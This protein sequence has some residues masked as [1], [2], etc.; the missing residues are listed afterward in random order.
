[1]VP[2]AGLAPCGERERTP[3]KR[4]GPPVRRVADLV[5]W[6]GAG[7]DPRVTVRTQADDGAANPTDG[8]PPLRELL[9]LRQVLR[10]LELPLDVPGADA[11][12][13]VRR[14]TI[15]QLDDYV[16][17][18]F[19]TLDAPVLAV[20]GGSTGA[21]KSTL[22][23]ALV[24]A[25]V[26]RS[27]AIR[28]TTRD[29]V[30][31]HHP[32]DGAW[33]TDARILP[34]LARLQGGTPPAATPEPVTT[35]TAAPGP[36][37]LVLAPTPALVPG[38]ALLD[39][40]DVDSVVDANRALATQLLAAADLW[41]FVTSANRY[42]D[43]VPWAL[44]REAASRD[45]EVAVVLDRVPARVVDEVRA[46]LRAMLDAEGLAGAPLFTVLETDLGAG[47]L[48]PV[49]AVSE[50]RDWLGALAGDATARAAVVRRTLT[51]AVAALA[52]RS[53]ALARAA[54]AQVLGAARLHG[55]VDEAYAAAT[56]AVLH[57]TDD[58]SLLRGEVLARWQ[59]FVGTGEL[60]RGLQ[61]RVGVVRDRIGAFLRGRPQ[62][63]AE[64]SVAIEHGLAS[65][66][67]MQAGAAADHAQ[68]GLDAD[69]A[70]RALLAG[71]DLAHASVGFE[72]V[73]AEEIRRWQ[74]AL[75]DLVRSQGQEKRTT[76]RL[77]AFGVNG[78][79]V[80]LMIVAF[81]STGGL[82]GAEIGIAGGTA[83]VAQKVLEAVF[84][85]QAVRS[86]ARTALEDLRRRCEALMAGERDAFL[87]RLGPVAVDEGAGDSLRDA[88]GAARA[89]VAATSEGGER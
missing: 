36:S 66:V 74:G 29:P 86:L 3:P 32:A 20:V 65:L 67:L 84:G 87:A 68:A 22:V 83:I 10:A 62:P 80:A 14:E 52:Q 85:D 38:L 26:S 37:C 69:P 71:R 4:R 40:P 48:L 49:E 11:A 1:M 76:A 89:A 81:A 2:E 47:G 61:G 75:L 60:F 34:G 56:E 78:V 39:A 79:G 77:L 12:R 88:A 53:E 50:V 21:G 28:P 33:F 6:I 55:R 13:A 35:G 19:R 16:V 72:R 27:G 43:A 63:A 46:D 25:V 18:R 44:L 7:H 59:E 82:L 31:V 9:R 54:D 58:G 73:A 57:A 23:N 70:G 51:G 30:L 45:A 41:V 8:A 15:A 24:G 5:P 17:P 64:V 42:A